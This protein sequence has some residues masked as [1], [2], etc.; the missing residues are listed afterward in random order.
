MV[1]IVALGCERRGRGGDG[2]RGAPPPPSASAAASAA[3]GGHAVF[4]APGPIEAL[5][6]P[7]GRAVGRLEAGRAYPIVKRGGPR[8]A[9]CKLD[10][11]GTP[12]WVPCDA[13]IS[14]GPAAESPA[15]PR[16]KDCPTTCTR[17]PLFGGAGDLRP[18]EREVLAL[19]PA[20]PDAATP[21]GELRRFF[22]AHHDDRRIQRAL[23]AAGRPGGP[24]AR[25]GNI[26]WLTGLWVGSGPR[27]A[28]T[29]VFCGDD[30]DRDK[31][32]GLHWLPRYAQLEAEGKVCY[33]GPVRGKDPK[34]GDQYLI[35]YD[36][37]APWSC[38]AKSV[39]GFPAERD[40]LELVSIA[41]RAFTR[42]CTRRGEASDGGVYPAGG[43]SDLRF[44][45]WCGTRNGTYGIASFYPT[46]E[47]ATCGE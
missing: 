28:F 11:S 34:A 29:H 47:R 4:T 32:G 31:L 44:R 13:A 22:A 40:P 7:D 26:D 39:G 42:C 17:P 41:T 9:W 45:I 21:R 30:W 25:E 2:P 16:G 6:Q 33:G 10:V 8:G 1:G 46:D 35:R 12:G 18:V 23:S 38:G 19:C 27:N 15:P 43:A 20:R 37:V 5:D 14:V 3:A 24:G 36:A